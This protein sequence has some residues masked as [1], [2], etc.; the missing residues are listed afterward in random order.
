MRDVLISEGLCYGSNALPMHILSCIGTKR[1]S[2]ELMYPMG[3]QPYIF[4]P[5]VVIKKGH[6]SVQVS[7]ELEVRIK[8]NE[9]TKSLDGS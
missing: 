3:L 7:M 4:L 8:I 6:K 1:K 2:G 9:S 5:P